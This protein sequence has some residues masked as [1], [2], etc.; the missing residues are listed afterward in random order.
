MSPRFT[1][2]TQQGMS[3]VNQG[4][5]KGFSF[6]NDKFKFFCNKSETEA[7]EQIR[8]EEEESTSITS[9]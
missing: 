4:D 7:S 6:V 9:L 5:F 2:I 1:P 3:A 8:A